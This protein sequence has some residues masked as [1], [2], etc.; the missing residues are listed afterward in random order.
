MDL[1]ITG[2]SSSIPQIEAGNLQPIAAF[3]PERFN[4][5]KA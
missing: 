5:K 3:G 1:G 2:A 4:L